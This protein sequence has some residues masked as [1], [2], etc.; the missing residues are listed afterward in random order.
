MPSTTRVISLSATAAYGS[1]ASVPCIDGCPATSTLSLMKVGTPLKNASWPVP[2]AAA[3]RAT[4]KAAYANAFSAG[5]TASARAMAASTTSARPT[6]P[7][8]MAS[9][10]AT[11]SRSPRASS[12]KACTRDIPG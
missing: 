6:R 1:H 10:R 12:T 5:L 9:A 2:I 7:D 3:S 4:S 11:A 8:R